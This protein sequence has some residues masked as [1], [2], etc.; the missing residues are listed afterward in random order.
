[1]FFKGGKRY[2]TV[3]EIHG[4]M[5]KYGFVS[6]AYTSAENVVYFIKSAPIY[7]EQS[8]DILSDMMVNAQFPEEEIQKEK[9]VVIQEVKMYEDDPRDYLETRFQLRYYGEN[10]YGRPILWPEENIKKFS[11]EML[12]DYKN[13]LYTKDN[14]VIVV[15]GKI[16]DK[17]GMKKQIEKQFKDLPSEKTIS[18][19]EYIPYAPKEHEKII[20]KPC[21]QSHIIICGKWFDYF[22]KQ[23]YG[24]RLLSIIVWW[25]QSSRLYSKVREELGLCYYLHSTH[26]T[27]ANFWEFEICAGL[28]KEKLEFWISTIFEILEEIAQGKITREE[29]ENAKTYLIGNYQMGIEGSLE[30]ASFYGSQLIYKKTPETLEEIT[31]HFKNVTYEEVLDLCSMLKRENLYLAYTK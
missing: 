2:K 7:R 13:K 4:M 31:E 27:S 25:N 8:L 12:F 21:E 17:E 3:K 9:G 26:R 1:M 15:A 10:S 6:N 22:Q 23:K 16:L 24:A 14:I 18:Q 30:F 20:E 28:N 5:D 11:R 29:F 19:Q